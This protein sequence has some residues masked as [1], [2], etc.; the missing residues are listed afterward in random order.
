MKIIIP[1]A[2]RGSRLRPHTLTVPK[3][4]LP[5]AGKPIVQRIVEDL[6]KAFPGNVEEVAYIIGDFGE[7]VEKDLVAIAASLGAKGTIY[8]Q[9]VPLGPAHAISMAGESL[10]GPCLVAFA[11][12]L[13]DASFDFDT[14]QDG[15][16]WVQKVEDPSSYGV[17]T[18]DAD[19]V[20]T[21]FVEKSPTFVSDQAIVG[22]YYFRE[23]EQLRDEI[24]YMLEHN[25]TDKG[26]FQIT[27]ALERLRQKGVRFQPASI[28][29]WLDCGNK[30]NVIHTN[31]RMLELT[32]DQDLVSASATIEN[33]VIIPPCYIG[34]NA[35]IKNAV[36]GPYVSLG[37]RS[38][39][40]DAV[41]K[42][43]VIQ[44]DSQI[45]NVTLQEAMIGSQVECFG[46]K[47]EISLGDY[48][49]FSL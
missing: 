21:G 7:Q 3:P 42:T 23:G 32:K 49:K 28:R 12:T 36:V 29:E 18:T 1:M 38:V 16:I 4:L 19:N 39:V 30:D 37:H 41:I 22:I 5:V 14:S 25:I 40:E 45:K 35:V 20:I 10:S 26:E 17:V 8:H 2:G 47:T 15:F 48:S 31:Q 44:N 13:F 33:S 6:A 11:D 9:E 27:T 24:R 43:S 34:E 46:K